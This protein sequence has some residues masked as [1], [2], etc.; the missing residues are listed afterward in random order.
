MRARSCRTCRAEGAGASSAAYTRSVPRNRV[1]IG[2]EEE[3][4]ALEAAS[5]SVRDGLGGCVLV[6]G[7]A[8]IGKTRLVAHA[9]EQAA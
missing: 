5:A 4:V 7:E 6:T 1:L 2:R 9:F 3:R 8:G